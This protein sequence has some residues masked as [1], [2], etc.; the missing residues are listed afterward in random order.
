VAALVPLVFFL[1]MV[2]LVDDPLWY[3]HHRLDIRALSRTE[4]T[5]SEVCHPPK[6]LSTLPITEEKALRFNFTLDKSMPTVL[7]LYGP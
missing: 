1:S 2:P 4:L 3:Q 5:S 6:Y 7:A